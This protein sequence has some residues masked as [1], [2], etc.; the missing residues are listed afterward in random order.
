MLTAPRWIIAHAHLER[1]AAI[2]AEDGMEADVGEVAATVDVVD[3]TDTGK[4]AACTD[5]ASNP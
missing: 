3:V 1:G 5:R 4:R 2:G